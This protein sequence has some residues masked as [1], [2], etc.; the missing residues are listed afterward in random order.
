I[1]KEIINLFLQYDNIYAFS[2]LVESFN[3]FKVKEKYLIKSIKLK[4]FKISNY[5]FNHFFSNSNNIK[6]KINQLEIWKQTIDCNINSNSNINNIEIGSGDNNNNNINS[7]SSS[8][9][10]DNNKIFKFLVNQLKF[11]IPINLVST[12]NLLLPSSTSPSAQP[13][14]YYKL[15]YFI[16]NETLETLIDSCITIAS[17]GLNLKNKNNL[18]QIW[19]LRKL[20]I[21]KKINSDSKSKQENESKYKINYEEVQDIK[22]YKFLESYQDETFETLSL[23]EINEI[24]NKFT[25]DQLSTILFKFKLGCNNSSSNNNNNN[26]FIFEKNVERIIKMLLPFF[27]DE[28]YIQNYSFYLLMYKCV[29]LEQNGYNK[30]KEDRFYSRILDE[31]I[32][33]EV[34]TIL[35]RFCSGRLNR[36][37]QYLKDYGSISGGGIGGGG[38]S[39]TIKH[40]FKTL[41]N[42]N[43]DIQLVQWFLKNYEM[44]LQPIEEDY[45]FYSINPNQ[46]TDDNNNNNNNYNKYCCGEKENELQLFNFLIENL[47]S[48]INNSLL[49]DNIL[50]ILFTKRV[51]LLN[52]LKINYPIEYKLRLDKFELKIPQ[53]SMETK[54]KNGYSS[55]TLEAV[56][57]LVENID[58]FKEK[59]QKQLLPHVFKKRDESVETRISYVQSIIRNPKKLFVIFKHGI[60]RSLLLFNYYETGKL[61]YNSPNISV[62]PNTSIG[63]ISVNDH[64]LIVD[65]IVCKCDTK[66]IDLIINSNQSQFIE[67]L[68]Y[69]STL[70]S[71]LKVFQYIKSTYS[72]LSSLAQPLIEILV[73]LALDCN[74][75]F[76][77]TYFKDTL[78]FDSKNYKSKCKSLIM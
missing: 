58:D 22:F 64:E 65:D 18:N 8:S 28:D 3:L 77:I 29:T 47:K 50:R 44:K 45:L 39:F 7:T 52:H 46:Q 56:N 75:R 59:F 25:Q 49:N 60:Q 4:A 31:M 27:G 21:L 20:K 33:K 35:F 54:T 6:N 24:K 10:L 12:P 16:Y 36:Q 5:L 78:N 11:E 9:G 23:L 71:Q 2:S 37:I 34:E 53:N 32:H 40:Y 1:L 62:I 70:Y 30:V 73:T 66:G 13:I 55:I 74:H 42:L 14:F 17:L 69:L 61:F 48:N 51:D 57:F 68:L 38:R 41:L 19:E 76:L 63:G 72:L 67:R 43:S 26:N 15:D